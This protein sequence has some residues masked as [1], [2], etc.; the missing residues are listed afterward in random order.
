[1]D[2]EDSIKTCFKK[3]FSTQ[4]RASRSEFWYFAIATGAVH[5]FQN[6]FLNYYIEYQYGFSWFTVLNVAIAVALGIPACTAAARRMHDLD[7]LQGLGWLG[8][9]STICLFHFSF[10]ATLQEVILENLIYEIRIASARIDT[11]FWLLCFIFSVA[12]F[13]F[14]IFKGTTG[15]NKYGPDPLAV[16]KYGEKAEKAETAGSFAPSAAASR[17]Q[18]PGATN[19]Q[20]APFSQ[21][22]PAPSASPANASQDSQD[23]SP[24]VGLTA[25]EL[26]QMGY[27]ELTPEQIQQLQ[28]LNQP[29]AQN[30]TNQ[31]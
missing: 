24:L 16:E 17:S 7:M 19:T 31:P 30:T 28:A 11:V 29:P 23:S 18:A 9:I 15:P 3:Y 13:V 26:E 25:A 22:P 20:P 6:F 10:V 1:M 12:F 4:G 5:V 14:G 27:V 8:G 2:F 21:Q